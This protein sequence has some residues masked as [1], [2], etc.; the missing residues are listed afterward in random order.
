VKIVFSLR[1]LPIAQPRQRTRTVVAHGK[2]FGQNYTPAKHPVN[3]FKA[4]LAFAA[5]QTYKGSPLT[6][7]LAVELVFIFPRPQ[8][9]IWKSKPM[10]R[11]WHTGRPDSENVAK[12]CLDSLTGICWADDSQVCDLHIVKWIAAGHDAAD[13]PGVSVSIEEL[14]P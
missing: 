12:A 13:G 2:V 4:E 11:E 5:Q 8:R 7:P 6:G 9:L 1:T 10:P 14:E 3:A